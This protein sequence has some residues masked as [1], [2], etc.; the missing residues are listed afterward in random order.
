M[1]EIVRLHGL[2]H[3]I[4]TDRGT[5]F[6]SD[7]WKATMGNQESNEHSAWLSINKQRGRPKG[8]KLNWNNTYQNASTINETIGVITYH[9]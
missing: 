3:D 7:L 2:P 8:Q 1:K 4:I 9:L 5:V 6:T